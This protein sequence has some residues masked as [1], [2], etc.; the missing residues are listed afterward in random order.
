MLEIFNTLEPFFK[1]NYRRINVREYAR[2]QKISP[3]SSSKRL[4]QFN[5]EGLLEKEEERNYIFYIAN[6]KNRVFITLSQTYWCQQFK[7]IGLLPY[8]EQELINPTIILFGS[9]AKAEI[10]KNSDIDLAIF[11]NTKKKLDVSSFEKKS[12]RKI[13]IFYFLRK[14]ELKNKELFNNIL[15]GFKVGGNW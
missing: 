9:F 4:E 14:E 11:S 13:Q 3:P 2:I 6:K 10:T 1:E 7:K 12:G 5:K 8:L 15:N